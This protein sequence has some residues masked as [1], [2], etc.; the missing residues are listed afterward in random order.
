[1]VGAAD[2][3]PRTCAEIA[4]AVRRQGA[5]PLGDP[6]ELWRRM[7]FTVLIW[8]RDDHLRNHGFP[9][10][11]GGVAVVAGVRP[12]REPGARREF[13]G[14]DGFR[15]FE[16]AESLGVSGE[17]RFRVHHPTPLKAILFARRSLRGQ[18]STGI[19]SR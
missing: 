14:G 17:G 13:A 12:E 11:S 4:E 15:G 19:R 7:V 1:M 5:D 8:N 3:E 6:A 18:V 10:R 9:P 2:R 16:V